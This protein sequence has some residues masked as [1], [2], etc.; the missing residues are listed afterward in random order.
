MPTERAI[1][2]LS[3]ACKSFIHDNVKK[4]NK[5]MCP[6]GLFSCNP[7]ISFTYWLDIFLF[8]DP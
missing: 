1:M 3:S 5:K 2:L 7:S 8:I 4:V 6:V